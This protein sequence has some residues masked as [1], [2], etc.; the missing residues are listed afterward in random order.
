MKFLLTE[1]GVWKLVNSE[2]QDANA[3]NATIRTQ[4][5]RT[6]TTRSPTLQ[7]LPTKAEEQR[8]SKA[9]Y[10]LYQSCSTIPQSHIADEDDP[11]TIWSTLQ[12]LFSRVN[13]DDEAGKALSE[14]FLAEQF[15]K[16]KAVDEYAAKLRNYQSQLSNIME[17]RL[18]D[19]SL[20]QQ[21]IRGLSYQY[22][23]IVT[24]IRANK[25]EFH[26][27]IK[28]LNERERTL[29]QC[30]QSKALVAKS[31]KASAKALVGTTESSSQNQQ[32][33]KLLRRTIAKSPITAVIREVINSRVIKLPSAL[34]TTP[35]SNA[36][37]APEQDTYNKST[38]PA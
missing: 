5:A 2:T 35:K 27:A 25:S 17:K 34:S 23:D 15:H 7:H 29:R 14:E 4:G 36:G 19:W 33:R 32:N 26:Q 1:E 10:L 28:M 11:A 3:A 22:D 20:T 16:Y 38:A 6:R 24:T 21:L 13:E 37:T 31:R 8:S 30:K 18:T 12:D 9:A